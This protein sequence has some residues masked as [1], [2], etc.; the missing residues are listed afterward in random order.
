MSFDEEFQFAACR[1]CQK[2]GKDI[3]TCILGFHTLS[4]LAEHGSKT[5]NFH[6]SITGLIIYK[7]E[8]SA[9]EAAAKA[10]HHWFGFNLLEKI[11][12]PVKNGNGNGNGNEYEY[13][14]VAI[15]KSRGN[16]PFLSYSGC[17][18]HAHKPFHCKIYPLLYLQHEYMIAPGCPLVD[19]P[20]DTNLVDMGVSL[21]Q[22]YAIFCE[23]HRSQ[24][25]SLVIQL[26]NQ[27]NLAIHHFKST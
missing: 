7:V 6:D 13:E 27:Y 15:S 19:N 14:F 10:W 8:K 4:Y 12:L 23:K 11:V 16:C 2:C 25:H 3:P 24:Y 21:I 1:E 9:L 26:K 20:T 5:E 22:N 17:S 18:L